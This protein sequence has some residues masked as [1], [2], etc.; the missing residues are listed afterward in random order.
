MYEKAEKEI[1]N[2]YY[3]L[4]V[5]GINY[6]ETEKHNYSSNGQK[7]GIYLDFECDCENKTK[8]T[9][10]FNLV[11]SGKIMS[12]GCTKFNNPKVI[13]DL[14]GKKFGRLTVIGRDLER[15]SKNIKNGI[16]GVH[17]LCQCDCG[18]PILSSVTGYQLKTGHTQ[19]C[20][21]YASEQIVKRNKK[22]S[23][24]INNIIE[25]EKCVI[26]LDDNTNQC[27]IDKEDYDIVKRWYWRKTCKRGN[28]DKGY[29]VTNIKDNDKYSKSVLMIHQVIA[30]I[31]YGKYDIK[32]LVPDHLSR[33]TDDNRKCNLYL[34]SNQNN[35][36]NRGLS[37]TNTS[38]KTGV[39]FRT[40]INMWQAYIT[41]N[42]KTKHLGFFLNIDD[43]IKARKEA[44]T[45]YKFTCD[46]VVDTYDYKEGVV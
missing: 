44:E 1:G 6:E 33:N 41:V 15:D 42:Y 9:R 16:K 11:K 13:E 26:L 22:Y 38:G 43:A 30:E 19:S 28:V 32:N 21:C 24:K 2:K 40:N 39:S 31:K 18:N 36:H 5:I 17:W 46:D 7:Y 37:K 8:I 3:H 4:T 12:C 25:N 34:K 23:T 29:W 45:K 14:T 20:G 10:R 27:I 35:S